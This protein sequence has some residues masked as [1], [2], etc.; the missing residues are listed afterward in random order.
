M[1]KTKNI[2]DT[3]LDGVGLGSKEEEK[4][5]EKEEETFLIKP[6]KKGSIS[7]ERQFNLFLLKKE[8]EQRDFWQQ[9]ENEY[10]SLY[11]D[12]DDPLF[13]VKIAKKAEFNSTQYDGTIPIHLTME[14]QADLL[15][16]A[17]FELAPHQSFVRNFL[18]YQTPYNSLLLFHGLGTG[19][20]CSAIGV[21]EEM[22]HYLKQMGISKR[23]L[24]VASPNVQDNFRLQLF[25]ERKLKKINGQWNMET[26]VGNDLLKEINTI[27]M[28]GM[29][30]E[31]VVQMVKSIIN[32]S[33]VF[34]GYESFA[35]Y[36]IKV[37][38][39][40][41]NIEGIAIGT[42]KGET[43]EKLTETGIRNLDREFN[44]RLIVIDEIHNIRYADDNSNKKVAQYLMRLVESAK[45]MRLLLLS[46]TP[47]FNS[48]KEIVFL[49]NIMNTNDK[50]GKIEVG[51]IFDDHGNF[52]PG[53][54]EL[55]IRKA[56]GYIS[57]VRGENPFTFPYRVYP[58]EF[59]DSNH[60][61]FLNDSIMK[62]PSFQ[63]NG[64]KIP[65]KDKLR[66]L[67]VFVDYVGDYQ[68]LGYLYIIEYLKKKNFDITTKKGV[69][70]KMPSFEMME[71]LGYSILQ[72]P[73]EALNIVYPLDELEAYIP[74]LLEK[75]RVFLDSS[76]KESLEQEKP[77]EKP[78][79]I[80]LPR[81][82]TAELIEEPPILETKTEETS[83]PSIKAI[84]SLY[85]ALGQ[86]SPTIAEGDKLKL[87]TLPSSEKSIGS[88][89]FEPP[90]KKRGRPRKNPANGGGEEQDDFYGWYSGGDQNGFNT[91]DFYGWYS[92]GD[93]EDEDELEHD[94]EFQIK[95]GALT[96]YEGLSR[97]MDFVDKTT[98]YEK[99]SFQYRPEYAEKRIFSPENIGKY[100]SKI[101]NICISIFDPT[102]DRVSEGIILIYSQYIDAG[103]IPMALALE[104]MGFTR[105][106]AGGAKSLFK[107][108]PVDA[109]D[110]QTMMSRTSKREGVFTPARYTMIT[111]DPRISPDN[112]AEV[113]ALTNPENKDGFKIKVVLIS[114]AGTEGI[115]FK[116]IRQVHI[117]EPW[118]NMNRVEQIIGRAVRNL[119]HKDLP[120][121]KR[122]VQIFM[123]GTLLKEQA[124]N[125]EEK[126]YTLI[127]KPSKEEAADLYV[128]R[129]AES[130][131]VLIGRI[132]R[133]LKRTAVD[134]ILNYRQTNYTAA[135]FDLALRSAD[136]KVKQILSNAKVIRNFKIG[137][138]PYTSACDY[139]EFCDYTCSPFQDIKEEDLQ[140]ETYDEKFILVNSE[141]L[142]QKIKTCFS[143]RIDG[144]FFYKKND[145]I[146]EINRTKKY[147]LIQIYSAL[148]QLIED[149]NEV[150]V[151]K[152][153][154]AGSLVNIGDYYF[155]QPREL[156]N[157]DISVFERSTPVDYKNI[158]F[159]VDLKKESGK[160]KEKVQDKIKEGNAVFDFV[161]SKYNLTKSGGGNEEEDIFYKHC[162]L[163]IKKLRRDFGIDES[164]LYRFLIYHILDFL[165]LKEKIDLLLYMQTI[166]TEE[167]PANFIHHYFDEKIQT[168]GET[169]F[170][171]LFQENKRR[172][173]L[174]EKGT[175]REAE[176]EDEREIVAFLKETDAFKL[177]APFS[178]IVGFVGEKSNQPGKKH[179]LVFKTKN[180]ENLRNKGA[181]CSGAGKKDQLE[182]LN[183]I[184]AEAGIPI[185]YTNENTK[186][187]KGAICCFIEFIL[188]YY[189]ETKPEKTWFLDVDMAKIYTF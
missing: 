47:M 93:E 92:G 187:I 101:K 141:K 181:D 152:Y 118:Y 46:A 180:M 137:D 66:L 179:E 69:V 173:Y 146:A 53:G 186:D 19:K 49:L 105:S 6:K 5:K 160:E 169:S 103:L 84:E 94:D 158:F 33:Y 32:T 7:K 129:M 16:Q 155:F 55:L 124:Y 150:I 108:S 57:Y 117:L 100:S 3:L 14:Q 120:F 48:Y 30:K 54:E 126:T 135:N 38:R 147:P 68:N 163:A 76:K 182:T 70:R 89:R 9:N 176:P 172:F 34:M 29:D 25:D 72:T 62:Y 133:L 1:E 167:T 184:L 52:K 18:S 11:P 110:S 174:L 81:E 153:N 178:H 60:S 90:K 142:I 183:K 102:S 171:V 86:P 143:D 106:P 95:P 104:E 109:V 82:E 44:G 97:V 121:E 37:E 71:S 175:W 168:K 73:L 98:P 136:R 56:T 113:K 65:S 188:R 128:Y 26:C 99:G 156:N 59:T 159:T 157:Q 177:K 42:R 28:Q 75:E 20:T 131:A 139:M 35:N 12:L 162:F 114:Q 112:N 63:M 119:S 91:E 165:S 140:K 40:V 67:D 23:I 74:L 13:N 161:L 130:K 21:C 96:G 36:I 138:K 24:I 132:S 189:Q 127:E 27:T 43:M 51:D 151:D 166:T 149:T 123:H 80:I 111:G 15:S 22:R 154:R 144:R 4:E 164:V 64:K 45:N 170:L 185:V 116:F 85:E 2:I 79:Q 10:S 17:D 50:R 77:L 78:K 87:T 125:E 107:Q 83:L 122:N 134:C 41:K 39:G 58:N 145:L 31:K 61:F 148:T 8:K 115:D 88:F